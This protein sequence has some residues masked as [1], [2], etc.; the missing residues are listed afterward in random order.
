MAGWAVACSPA[1]EVDD[2]L[3]WS[4]AG[5]R[6]LGLTPEAA[7]R[8]FHGYNDH[9]TV[10]E[11]LDHLASIDRIRSIDD[12]AAWDQGDGLPLAASKH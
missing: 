7:T 8:L 9:A 12:L 5:A 10:I 11:V 4:D 3:T 1:E 6:A 2:S